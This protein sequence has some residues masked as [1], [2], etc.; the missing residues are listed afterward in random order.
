MSRARNHRPS[1][2]CG[3]AVHP[4]PM[5]STGNGQRCTR[6]FGTALLALWQALGPSVCNLRIAYGALT[7][8][9][10]PSRAG[11]PMGA[12]MSARSRSHRAA[13]PLGAGRSRNNSRLVGGVSAAEA[14]SR[15]FQ[16][17]VFVQSTEGGGASS[18]ALGPGSPRQKFDQVAERTGLEPA[19]PGV[20]GRYSNQLNYRSDSGGANPIG[21]LGRCPRERYVARPQ[22]LPG[23]APPSL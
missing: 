23:S 16:S 2:R 5:V 3:Y 17:C 9:P 4:S 13:H 10:S 21:R 20:T 14:D 18:P 19:T 8:P 1:V 12:P 11:L 22:E 7:G 15:N 6:R